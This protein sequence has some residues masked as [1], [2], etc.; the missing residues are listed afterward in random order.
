MKLKKMLL[1][2]CLIFFLFTIST[3]GASENNSTDQ[4]T[5]ENSLDELEIIDNSEIISE[6]TQHNDVL[7]KKMIDNGIYYDNKI[8]IQAENVTINGFDEKMISVRVKNLDY[9]D[10]DNSGI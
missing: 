2:I 10:E 7:N 6:P 3:V 4:L 8:E 5:N 9:D 1:I